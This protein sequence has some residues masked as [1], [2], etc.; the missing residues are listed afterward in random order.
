MDKIEFDQ[1]PSSIF[2]YK[3]PVMNIS[4]ATNTRTVIAGFVKN[5]PCIH[6]L[7]PVIVGFVYTQIYF[8]D[9]VL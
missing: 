5:V 6:S 9:H 8:G 2:G 1:N 3:V 7:N 4:S